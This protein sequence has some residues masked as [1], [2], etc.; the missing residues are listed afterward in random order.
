MQRWSAWRTLVVGFP[1]F[2][3]RLGV[4]RRSF[5]RGICTRV[6]GTLGTIR[7]KLGAVRLG[8]ITLG[9]ISLLCGMLPPTMTG[10]WLFAALCLAL[11]ATGN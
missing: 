5:S 4:H 1:Y 11:G 2:T 10:F 8:L 6:L 9:A 7:N 3:G